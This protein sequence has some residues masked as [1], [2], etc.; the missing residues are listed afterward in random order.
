MTRCRFCAADLARIERLS[1]RVRTQVITVQPASGDIPRSA[2]LRALLRKGL[3]LADTRE[4]TGAHLS[5]DVPTVEIEFSLSARDS[6][7]LATLQRALGAR[8]PHSPKPA[9]ARIARAILLMA[10]VDAETRANLP[11]FAR[12]V[13]DARLSR[14]ERSLA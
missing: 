14:I 8:F 4:I 6:K 5:R 10:L 3:D 12:A 9:M 13:L 7:R 11:S 1:R 2:V